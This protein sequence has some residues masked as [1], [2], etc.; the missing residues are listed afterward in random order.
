MFRFSKSWFSMVKYI[1]VFSSDVHI[2]NFTSDCGFRDVVFSTN[3]RN[4]DATHPLRTR[5][6][7]LSN[8]AENSYV[9]IHRPNVK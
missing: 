4:D 7:S 1:N 5:R 8:V 3:P 2:S 6:L 9:Y